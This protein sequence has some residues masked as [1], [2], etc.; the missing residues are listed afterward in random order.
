MIL[1]QYS[2]PEWKEDSIVEKNTGE[3]PLLIHRNR[4]LCKQLH[5]HFTLNPNFLILSS[6]PIFF[7]VKVNRVLTISLNSAG[8]RSEI[9]S[10]RAMACHLWVV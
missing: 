5:R 2:P 9:I 6:N 10:W 3:N 1:I 8:W 4:F 7:I